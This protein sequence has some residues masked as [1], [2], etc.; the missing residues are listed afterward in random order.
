ML[1]AD[2]PFEGGKG[3][4]FSQRDGPSSQA[5]KTRYWL[6]LDEVNG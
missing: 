3:G 6:I 5:L 1:R 4:P 2:I